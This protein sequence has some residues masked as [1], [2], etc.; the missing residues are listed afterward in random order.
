M[1]M[2]DIFEYLK[3]GLPWEAALLNT[4]LLGGV[5]SLGSAVQGHGLPR[6]QE[7]GHASSVLLPRLGEAGR[8]GESVGG[9]GED[10]TGSGRG[11][12]GRRLEL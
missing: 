7:V 1:A 2:L 5:A 6:D 12:R 4:Q 3:R 9:A 11:E 10:E 8:G